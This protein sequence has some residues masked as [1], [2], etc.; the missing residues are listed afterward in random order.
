[1]VDEDLTLVCDLHLLWVL[2]VGQLRDIGLSVHDKHH[3]FTNVA[4][5]VANT[6][7]FMRNPQEVGDTL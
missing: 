3:A 2:F 6:F 4:T 7:E 5:V 1:M